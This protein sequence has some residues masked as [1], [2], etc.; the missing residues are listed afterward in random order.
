MQKYNMLMAICIRN[1]ICRVNLL[2]GMIKGFFVTTAITKALCTNTGG[3]E[4]D[5]TYLEV[6]VLAALSFG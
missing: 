3:L 1:H 5:H 2:P 6:H 4:V